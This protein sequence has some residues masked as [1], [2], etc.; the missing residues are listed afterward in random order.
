LIPTNFDVLPEDSKLS[1]SP[2]LLQVWDDAE[3]WFK[4]DDEFK[5]PKAI[6]NLRLYTNDCATTKTLK[7]SLFAELWD[8]CL[9]EYR[10][11]FSYMANEAALKFNHS[12][13]L[14]CVDFSWSGYNSALPEFIK[15]TIAIMM[16]LKTADIE[17]IFN[18]KKELLLQRYK[19]HYLQMVFRLAWS[20]MN[21]HLF[22]NDN[23]KS[24]LRLLLESYSYKDFQ[25]DLES[26]M[27]SGRMVFGFFGNFTTDSAI[28]TVN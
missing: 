14:G 28:E 12:I 24:K 23:Q 15:E 21:D 1:Q 22:E 25:S 2:V 6:V 7:G 10:R 9:Q 8:E 18:D 11:E 26:W 5:R 13:A 16:K 17:D 27:T 3:L 20:E 19:N 4:K